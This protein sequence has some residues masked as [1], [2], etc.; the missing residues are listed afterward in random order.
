M[1]HQEA[2]IDLVDLVSVTLVSSA[3]DRDGLADQVPSG[4]ILRL[5]QVQMIAEGGLQAGEIMQS[6]QL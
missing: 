3:R 4:I 6:P 2:F 5:S 1:Y